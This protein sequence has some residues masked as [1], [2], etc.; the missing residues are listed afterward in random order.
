MSKF[1][2]A[3][4][5]FLITVLVLGVAFMCTVSFS[6]GVDQMKTFNSIVSMMTKDANLGGMLADGENYYGGG[7]TAVYYPEGVISA[8]EYEDNLAGLE[9]V[10]EN[11]D[12]SDAS[13][14]DKLDA[15][16]E[17]T[18]KYERYP[19]AN[20]SIY[21]EKEVVYGKDGT[22][23]SEDF[24]VGFKNAVAL[25]RARFEGLHVEGA[26]VSVRDGYTVQVSLPRYAGAQAVILNYFS[27]TGAFTLGYGSNANTATK[28]TLGEDETIRDYVK[29]AYSMSNSGT[30]YV[31]V[32]FTNK[33]KNLI[34]SWTASAA[35]SA[36]T[37]FFYVGENAIISLSVNQQIN[38]NSLFISGS[39][40]EDSA[41]AVAVTIDSTVKNAETE[42]SFS[43]GDVVRNGAAFG[44]L[45][46]TML[47][48]A[49]GVLFVG[50][51]VFF[52]VRYRA[53]AFAHLYTFV[54]F[55]LVMILLVWGISFLH[56]GIETFLA[57]VLAGTLLAISNAISY[58]SARKEYALGKTMVS[59]VK[60]GYKRCFWQIFD[61]H[62][63]LALLAFITYF[64]ALTELGVFAFTLG[65]GVVLSGLCSL[66][67]NRFHWAALMTFAS[68]KGKFCNFK[69]EDEDDE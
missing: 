44:D 28:L 67:V 64:I 46:L 47:Y 39:Y 9:A 37:L 35:E 32:D 54:I 49:F 31:A 57:V 60:S 65:L 11:T 10:V 40:T 38:Q 21:F 7:Y 33:G 41:R 69:R 53:L 34:A 48:V 43:V 1:K 42:L 24:E 5:L 14:Q 23:I 50:M 17:Y 18:E 45:A 52:F 15:V 8:Q 62:I 25:F 58:E 66:A 6:Y 68:D 20:G 19:D 61:L 16:T 2:S 13:Y 26:S 12:E 36:T 30:A 63:A 56:L 22:E 4:A 27:Y 3:L 51:M 29:G 55:T 59:S